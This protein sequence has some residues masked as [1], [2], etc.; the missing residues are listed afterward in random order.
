M[1]VLYFFQLIFLFQ[2]LNFLNN[3]IPVNLQHLELT[4]FSLN[5]IR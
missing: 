5:G 1:K 2:D 4:F 3:F